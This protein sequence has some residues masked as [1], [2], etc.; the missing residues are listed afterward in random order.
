MN[1][2]EISSPE[3]IEEPDSEELA[4]KEAIVPYS[5]IEQD[6]EVRIL[7]RISPATGFGNA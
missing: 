7:S 5:E 6:T 3:E 2:N 4:F 1:L